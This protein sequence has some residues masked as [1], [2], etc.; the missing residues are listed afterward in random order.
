M[1]LV[2][3]FVP[4]I[5]LTLWGVL[6]PR[7][8]WERLQAWAHRRPEA[9]EPSAAA[10]TVARVANGVVLIALVA[11]AVG[12]A[13]HGGTSTA[14]PAPVTTP[15]GNAASSSSGTRSETRAAFDADVAV[16]QSS[17]SQVAAPPANA[18]PVPIQRYQPVPDGWRPPAWLPPFQ[19]LPAG[20]G[21][22]VSVAAGSAPSAVVVQETAERVTVSVYSGC[23]TCATAAPRPGQPVEVSLVAVRL[24]GPLGTRPVID[25][26]TGAAV[27]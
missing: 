10:F 8:Q 12:L 23:G 3:C 20:T 17:V 15:S 9:N 19:T 6:S 11:G 24:D 13:T 7:S 27:S 5:A 21:L 16:L 14:A 26:S 4:F 22:V 18:H 2:L 1:L 25:G